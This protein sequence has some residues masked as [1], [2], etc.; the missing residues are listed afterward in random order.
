MLWGVAVEIKLRVRLIMTS[1]INGSI[2]SRRRGLRTTVSKHR[3]FFHIVTIKTHDGKSIQ[4]ITGYWIK[5]RLNGGMA[6][7][8][9]NIIHENI[10]TYK[11]TLFSLFQHTGS[12]ST[13]VGVASFSACWTGEASFEAVSEDSSSFFETDSLSASS[14]DAE[15]TAGASYRNIHLH[16]FKFST[17]SRGRSQVSSIIGHSN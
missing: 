13:P 16:L 17:N 9:S 1:I 14:V 10:L 2:C 3:A 5:E 11:I 6:Y 12:A 4:L 15:V 7:G 8:I